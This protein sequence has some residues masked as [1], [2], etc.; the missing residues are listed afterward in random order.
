MH[1]TF[2]ISSDM[3]FFSI[4]SLVWKSVGASSFLFFL[5]NLF[6]ENIAC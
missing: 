1:D 4:I 2:V 6:V 5:I 3:I